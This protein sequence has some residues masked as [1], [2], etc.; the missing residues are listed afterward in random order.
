MV[1]EGKVFYGSRGGNVMNEF[2][3]GEKCKVDVFLHAC[4]FIKNISEEEWLQARSNLKGW[5]EINRL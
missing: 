2:T 4:E 5:V 3:Q 1:R